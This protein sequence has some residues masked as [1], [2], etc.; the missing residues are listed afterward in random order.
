[1][2]ILPDLITR[3]GRAKLVWAYMQNV[4][5]AILVKVTSLRI[6]MLQDHVARSFPSPVSPCPGQV[7]ADQKARQQASTQ[8]QLRVWMIHKHYNLHDHKSCTHELFVPSWHA[9]ILVPCMFKH[10]SRWQYWMTEPTWCCIR[11]Q[12]LFISVKFWSTN[13]T[14]SLTVSASLRESRKHQQINS[15]RIKQRLTI[16]NHISVTNIKTQACM[17]LMQIMKHKAMIYISACKCQ[18]QLGW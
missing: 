14:A 15:I 3:R 1:M 5:N 11:T 7:P 12:S 17:L 8:G 13:S 9:I 2:Q 18:Q 10:E 16:I 4:H 6:L